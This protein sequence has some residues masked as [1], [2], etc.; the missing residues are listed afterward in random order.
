MYNIWEGQTDIAD[1]LRGSIGTR[2]GRVAVYCCAKGEL[3]IVSKL[4]EG[5]KI[6]G[7]LVEAYTITND[8]R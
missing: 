3:C 4:I 1:L 8:I 5:V 7:L 2:V 6:R